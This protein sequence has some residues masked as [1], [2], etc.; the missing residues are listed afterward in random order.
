MSCHQEF[1]KVYIYLKMEVGKY[2]DFSE[3][4][5]L[6]NVEFYWGKNWDVEK[7]PPTFIKVNGQN[8][9]YVGWEGE[10]DSIIKYQ[11]DNYP[12]NLTNYKVQ[13]FNF[14]S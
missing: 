9:S 14:S 13:R 8:L 4:K 11:R 3:I 7:D 2:Y 5:T 10:D 1:W 6:K 12:Y